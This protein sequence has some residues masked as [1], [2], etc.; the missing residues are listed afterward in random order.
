MIKDS[1]FVFTNGKG[2]LT[3]W[4]LLPGNSSITTVYGYTYGGKTFD[5]PAN[6]STATANKWRVEIK[7]GE[8]Q[9]EDVFLNVLSTAETPVRPVLTQSEGQITVALGPDRVIFNKGTGGA[10]E[11]SGKRKDFMLGVR[12]SE[13]E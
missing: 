13:F 8:A 3:G 5:L 9:T 6:P 12:K 2:K 1:S 10:I 11:I 7:P 4:T